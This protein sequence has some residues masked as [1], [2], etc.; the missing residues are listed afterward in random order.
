MK[1]MTTV[2]AVN[3][4]EHGMTS[5]TM[6][7]IERSLKRWTAGLFLSAI[8]AAVSG[9]AGFTI[10]VMTFG[11]YVVPHTNLYALGTVFIGVSF[12]LFGLAAHCLDKAA[13]ADK[14][15]RLEYSR[16]HG[17]KDGEFEG[18]TNGR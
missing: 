2:I 1:K 18:S 11:G 14:A 8:L 16:K 6:T 10:A 5:T 17:L 7:S 12:I 13:A 15:I 3:E 9:L 4:I